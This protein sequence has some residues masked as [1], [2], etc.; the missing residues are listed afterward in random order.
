MAFPERL[1]MLEAS[2]GKFIADNV[3]AASTAYFHLGV[4][5]RPFQEQLFS[6]LVC[7]S[8]AITDDDDFPGRLKGGFSLPPKVL[9]ERLPFVTKGR[10][11]KKTFA[12]YRHDDRKV[13]PLVSTVT[14]TSDGSLKEVQAVDLLVSTGPSP[15][16]P[17]MFLEQFF[18]AAGLTQE[19]W[20]LATVCWVEGHTQ[21]EAAQRFN[22]SQGEVSKRLA[23][24]RTKLEQAVGSQKDSG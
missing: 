17:I 18:S 12:T 4:T 23:V 20:E 14:V 1:D 11:L 13:G 21:E 3:G 22:L 24:A 2:C 9:P 5:I 6:S 19:E 10:L 16:D 7:V 8:H 15:D